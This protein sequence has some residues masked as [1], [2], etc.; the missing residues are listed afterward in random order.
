MEHTAPP[1]ANPNAHD[2]AS[3]I[4]QPKRSW[5][6]R[7]DAAGSEDFNGRW[8]REHWMLASMFATMGAL[9]VAIVPGFNTANHAPKATR[10]TF[11]LQ[12]P[13]L[14]KTQ[15][16]T[17]AQSWQIV[18]VTKGEKLDSIFAQFNIPAAD[19]KRVLAQPGAKAA[20]THL[21]PGAE[22]AFDVPTPGVL[23]GLRYDKDDSTRIELTFDGS[24]VKSTTIH[25]PLERRMESTSGVI[26]GSLFDAGAKAGMNDGLVIQMA[27]VF[28]YD[29]DMAQDLQPGDSFQVVYEDYWR[30]GQLVRTGNILAASF[31][32]N[33]K[34]YFAY[35]YTHPN[36]KTEYVD[37]NGTPL[38]KTF[39]RTPVEFTRISSGF[40]LT[41]R[42]HPILGYMRAHT[43][44]DYAAP[45]GTPIVAAGDAKVLF[46]G[47]KGGYGNCII[48]DH[49][50][51]V[52][53]LYGHMSR[54]G[55][56]R[57]GQHVAQ[58]ATI[59]YVGMT[60]MAT[61]PHL[62]Y[63]FRINGQ[64][65]NPLSVTMPK[66]LPLEGAELASFRTQNAAALAQLNRMQLLTHE[67]VAQ[68]VINAP[69]SVK[70]AMKRQMLASARRVHRG[71]G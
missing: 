33:G 8:S 40:T 28:S 20:L 64:Y 16:P 2:S 41:G 4:R 35:R 54:F 60:G 30:D 17:P 48:L 36:G 68:K 61:G 10:A 62:H 22:L 34:R 57:V 49:G 39:M 21:R 67:T 14:P 47:Q 37:Q 66:P 26:A 69:E 15:A 3:P 6:K 45:T 24:K 7:L 18:S 70:K 11:A 63:E 44:V 38:K 19:Q 50:S 56:Y 25:R 27:K 52:T 46:E 29:I 31:D 23:R 43:G 51:G 1:A 42:M 13:A 32:N 9:V 71:R 59:G 12:L 53:T 55:G 58:G 65:R 5:F